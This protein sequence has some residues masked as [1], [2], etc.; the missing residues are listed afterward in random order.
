M[1]KKELE[2]QR[3]ITME[4][5]LRSFLEVENDTVIDTLSRLEHKEFKKICRSIYRLNVS[6]LPFEAVKK[7]D[8]YEGRVI[9]VYD[10]HHNFAPYRNPNQ[11]SVDRIH[12]E[13]AAYNMNGRLLS[14]AE[15]EHIR[16]N[17]LLSKYEELYDLYEELIDALEEHFTLES[18]DIS[19]I[20]PFDIPS[21]PKIKILMERGKEY[22]KYKRKW[23][24][25]YT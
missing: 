5:F 13:L 7:E 15:E 19:S 14:Q 20:G 1:N 12:E 25:K 11:K 6:C 18:F 16:Y 21:E 22:D 8:L 2:K 23:K 9:L 4:Q 10:V 17:E 3:K 24:I